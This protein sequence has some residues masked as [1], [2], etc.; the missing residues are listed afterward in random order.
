MILKWDLK[1]LINVINKSSLIEFTD[2]ISSDG[3]SEIC[4]ITEISWDKLDG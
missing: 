4:Y 2:E 3:L 1:R